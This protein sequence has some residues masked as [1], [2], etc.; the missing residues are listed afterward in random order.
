MFSLR[1]TVRYCPTAEEKEW[2]VRYRIPRRQLSLVAGKQGDGKSYMLLDLASK[3]SHGLN[4]PDGSESPKRKTLYCFVEDSPSD[5]RLRLENANAD[6]K[7]NM[8]GYIH[9]ATEYRNRNNFNIATSEG[10][11]QLRDAVIEGGFEWV[12][13]DPFNNFIG[14]NSRT[15]ND[16]ATRHILGELDAVAQE[17]N[18]GITYLMHF[19]K[20]RDRKGIDKILNSTGHSAFCRVVLFVKKHPEEYQRRLLT[21][22]KTNSTGELPAWEYKLLAVSD[23][24]DAG[25]RVE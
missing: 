9:L 24:P 15:D 12:I 6:L 1:K 17:C 8:V 19:S 22:E 4:M 2:I 14:G 18:V 3:L 20:D 21:V 11:K 13:I 16:S 10:I 5:V 25:A 23:N 7:N